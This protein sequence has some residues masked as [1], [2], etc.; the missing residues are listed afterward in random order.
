M[1]KMENGV[2]GQH[3]SYTQDSLHKAHNNMAQNR[4]LTYD[5]AMSSYM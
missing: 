3:L 2:S 5:T 1:L 4:V